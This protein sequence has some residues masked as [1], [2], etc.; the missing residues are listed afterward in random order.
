MGSEIVC[1]VPGNHDLWSIG[2]DVPKGIEKYKACLTIC[3]QLN[4]LTPEDNFYTW[5]HEHVNYWS[6]N[7]LQFF[8]DSLDLQLVK[9][10]HV[11]T[12]GGSI[13]A[14][15]S[16]KKEAETDSSV[17]DFIAR[18]KQFGLDNFA[19]LKQFASSVSDLKNTTNNKIKELKSQGKS[20]V[21]YGSPAKATTV[22]NYYGVNN[23]SID[24]II[25]DN[26]LKHNRFL[27]GMKI[28][29]MSKTHALRNP[30]D[31]IL[32]LAWNFLEDIK[33]NNVDL[34]EK[35]CKFITLKDL[36]WG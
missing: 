30:P 3:N 4:V 22:L 24:Y 27:P 25:E 5:N 23:E 16:A 13:R 1:P 14:F 28:P 35:G 11:N 34:V 9:V 15:I 7:T 19:T 32:V 20:I 36:N 29:I 33:K 2:K 6:V 10:E 21:G 26:E 18:E 8:F 17:E 31:Y 12:H